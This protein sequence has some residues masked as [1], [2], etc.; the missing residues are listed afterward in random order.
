[1]K[2]VLPQERMDRAIV[3]EV[4]PP[5]LKTLDPVHSPNQGKGSEPVKHVLPQECMDRAIV[6]EVSSAPLKTLDPVHSP[7]QDNGSKPVKYM[8][9]KER[10]GLTIVI[11]VSPALLEVL[12]TVLSQEIIQPAP[13]IK[14]GL[15]SLEMTDPELASILKLC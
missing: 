14:L 6:N 7:N 5:P 15:A 9:P 4:S 2:H 8:L 3:I 1:V 11:V 10:M 13:F 12:E